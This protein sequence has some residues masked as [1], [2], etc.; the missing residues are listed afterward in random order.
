MYD[1]WYNHIK[2][3]Y[4]DRAKLCYTDTDSLIIEIETEDVYADADM[5]KDAN[6]YDL[7]IIL[8][9]IHYLK[10]SHQINR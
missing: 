6:L 3:K 9:T 8:K 1:F 4:G 5:V 7:V 10:N 2:R